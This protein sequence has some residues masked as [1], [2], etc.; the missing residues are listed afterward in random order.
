MQA[1]VYGAQR[2]LFALPR[3]LHLESG[4]LGERRLFAGDDS[5]A[6]PDDFLLAVSLFRF[7]VQMRESEKFIG[8]M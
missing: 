6:F 4:I 2:I 3:A 8:G 7:F 5:A 1:S